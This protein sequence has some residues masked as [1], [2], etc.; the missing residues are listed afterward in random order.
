MFSLINRLLLFDIFSL[1]L[2]IRNVIEQ[3]RSMTVCTSSYVVSLT[4][5]L[6][7]TQS[8]REELSRNYTFRSNDLQTAEA[9]CAI[10]EHQ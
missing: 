6:L 5:L 8:E 3:M 4:R 2:F 7:D 1:K 9:H 10:H